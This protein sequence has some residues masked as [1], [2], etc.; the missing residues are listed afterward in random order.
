[1]IELERTAYHEAGHAVVMVVYGIGFEH[2]T[3]VAGED[4]LGHVLMTNP[5]WFHPDWDNSP[6]VRHFTRARI[7]GLLAGPLAEA[8][9]SGDADPVDASS[10]HAHAA[11]LAR[12]ATNSAE[13]A[14]EFLARL[15]RDAEEGIGAFWFH[16]VA[17][18]RM[19]VARQTLSEG[20]VVAIMSVVPDNPNPFA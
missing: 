17:V 1:M 6:Y 10:D 15:D 20:E 4:Y 13:S 2:V 18:A 8:E 14:S 19:L 7:I 12:F 5:P 9:F 16:I 11:D 3:I